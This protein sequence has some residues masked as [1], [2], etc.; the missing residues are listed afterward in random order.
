MSMAELDGRTK[1]WVV[2]EERVVYDDPWVHLSLLDVE[3]PGVK[4]FEYRVVR[5]PRV[6]VALILDQGRVLMLR[7]YRLITQQ[8]GWELPGGVIDTGEE[9]ARAAAREAEEETGYRPNQLNHLITYQPSIG[10]VDSPHEI[11]FGRGAVKT[12]KPNDPTEAG[13]VDWIPLD[14]IRSVINGDTLLSS[15][16]LVGLLFL[17]A[18][19]LGDGCAARER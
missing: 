5:L 19:D 7:R 17:L 15:G 14:R 18:N 9:G 3:P 11:Y 6:A 1:P 8:W 10:M 12:G 13:K 2:H 4:R 16:T